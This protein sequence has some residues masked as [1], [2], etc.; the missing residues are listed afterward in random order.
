[1][2]KV[3][4]YSKQLYK[5]NKIGSLQINL[6]SE[7]LPKV[8][9][10]IDIFEKDKM[11]TYRFYFRASAYRLI[12]YT[13]G[14]TKEEQQEYEQ[15]LGS[16]FIQRDMVGRNCVYYS[17]KWYNDVDFDEFRNLVDFFLIGPS[18]SIK[19][20]RHMRNINRKMF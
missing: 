2:D 16:Q 13:E 15:F 17:N 5:D 6:D 10:Y 3:L 20:P 4:Q 9:F 12:C 14:L 18:I 11:K 1:M 7:Y 19:L 8:Q